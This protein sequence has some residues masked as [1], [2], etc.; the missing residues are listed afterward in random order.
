[1]VA[2]LAQCLTIALLCLLCAGILTNKGLSC[3]RW[4]AAVTALPLSGA[5]VLSVYISHTAVLV[6]FHREEF[7]IP[8][9]SAIRM[10]SRMMAFPADSA[11]FILWMSV[12]V[13]SLWHYL[14]KKA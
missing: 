11:I 12:I 4:V 6:I 3:G 14:D 2:F 10:A 5:I 8:E 9:D 13:L 1:M 7:I